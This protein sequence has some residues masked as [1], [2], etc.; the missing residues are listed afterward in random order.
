MRNSVPGGIAPAQLRGLLE[1]EVEVRPLAVVPVPR[2]VVDE[3][4]LAPAEKDQPIAL[5]L[6]EGEHLLEGLHALLVGIE[7]R[8]GGGVVDEEKDDR[9]LARLAP[10]AWPRAATPGLGLGARRSSSEETR[11][12]AIGS[13]LHS[14]MPVPPGPRRYNRTSHEDRHHRTLLRRQE[15]SFPSTYRPARARRRVGGR[16][17]GWG[18]PGSR[19]PGWTPWPRL[20]KPKKKTCAT[21]EYVDVPGVAKGEGAALVDLPALRG[22]GRAP[23]RGARVRIGRGAPSRRLRGPAARRE[24]AGAG[25]DPGRP[26]RGGSP[27]RAP[28]GQHQEGEQAGGRG[29]ARALPEDEGAP[30]AGAAAPRARHYRRGASAGSATTPSSPRSRCCSW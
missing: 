22:R 3:D 1:G 18:W 16:R 5:A 26:L 21:V 19:T 17:P 15:H 12:V 6:E 28:R 20:Y 11:Q 10:R 30:R 14:T 25:A 4:L 2:D 24:H 7:R 23:A 29:R 9:P 8:E 27:P 13:R